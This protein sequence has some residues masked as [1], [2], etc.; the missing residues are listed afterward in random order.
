LDEQT[1]KDWLVEM[2][3][4]ITLARSLK[5]FQGINELDVRTQVMVEYPLWKI[6]SVKEVKNGESN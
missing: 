1:R 5:V 3:Y 4:P 6:T 2:Y